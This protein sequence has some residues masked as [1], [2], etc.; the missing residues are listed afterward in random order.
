MRYETKTNGALVCTLPAAALALSVIATAAAAV[1]LNPPPAGAAQAQPALVEDSGA[2]ALTPPP[3]PA[4]ETLQV[5]LRFCALPVTA[6]TQEMRAGIVCR[7][8]TVAQV[9]TP[10][11]RITSA[12]TET[13]A[14]MAR[15]ANQSSTLCNTTVVRVNITNLTVSEAATVSQRL[16]LR[17]FRGGWFP[18]GNGSVLLL[19]SVTTVNV[20]VFTQAPAREQRRHP[21]HARILAVF[22]CTSILVLMAIVRSLAL[23]H[24]ETAVLAQISLNTDV[25]VEGASPASSRSSGISSASDWPA[26]KHR[27]ERR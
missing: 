12:V 16:S 4:S 23:E 26:P 1:V 6:L 17:K 10:A 21:P 19:P 22:A 14:A 18:D 7:V 20:S 3:A 27:Y 8:A 24:Y 25:M 15:G 11:V 2:H 5:A 13:T 9:D